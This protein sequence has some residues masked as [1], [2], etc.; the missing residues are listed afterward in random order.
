LSEQ[1]KGEGAPAPETSE[2]PGEQ[3]PRTAPSPAS[4]ATPPTAPPASLPTPTPEEQALQD[5]YLRLAAEFDN[6]RKRSER[7][8]AEYRKRAQ[9]AILVSVLDVVDNLDRALEAPAPAEAA[10]LREGVAAIRAQLWHVLEREGVRPIEALG[11]RFDPFEM[12]AALRMP[13][14]DVAEGGVVREIQRGY[15]GRHHVLRPSKV[16]VSSGPPPAGEA[17]PEPAHEGPAGT[18]RGQPDRAHQPHQPHQSH[19]SHHPQ[20]HHSE[21]KK[22]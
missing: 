4:P 8:M 19:Q 13:S 9:D 16:I 15:K 3:A 7:D 17:A 11:R 10:K 18:Q 14:P 1:E 22:E 5:R 12:E 20:K 2:R 6:L 21:D